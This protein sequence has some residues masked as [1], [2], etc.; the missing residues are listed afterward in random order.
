[1]QQFSSSH[2]Y[3]YVYGCPVSA[4]A[5]E[6]STHTLI[7]VVMPPEGNIHSVLLEEE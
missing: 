4:G 5:V 3:H 1:M 2:P 6:H 7:G